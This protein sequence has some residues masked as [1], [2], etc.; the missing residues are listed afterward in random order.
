MP[1]PTDPYAQS[2]QQLFSPEEYEK[3]K[4]QQEA[5][6]AAA[7]A[8][9]QAPAQA[10]ADFGPQP[11]MVAPANPNAPTPGERAQGPLDQ[12]G[13]LLKSLP[14]QFA[15]WLKGLLGMAAAPAVVEPQTID[16]VPEAP[17]KDP[18]ER[19]VRTMEERGKKPLADTKGV[20]S[21]KTKKETKK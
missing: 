13:G 10:P 20:V 5:A 2:P 7:M 11:G 9:K 21:K 16:K 17:V 14:P 19:E 15:E 1:N 4:K 3:M 8:T 12:I 6:Q 18:E